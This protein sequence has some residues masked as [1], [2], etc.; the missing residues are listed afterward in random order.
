MP[1]GKPRDPRKEQH[2]R[3]LLERWQSSGL[4]VRA[5]CERHRD[6]PEVKVFLLGAGPGIGDQARER[7]NARVGREIVV[8][9]DQCI[10]VAAWYAQHPNAHAAP[11]RDPTALPGLTLW[12]ALCYRECPSDPAPA[13]RNT[14][15]CSESS[16]TTS[17]VRAT[18]A[19]I[20]AKSSALR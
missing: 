5:F 4:S 2:W 14:T 17:V 7:I 8:G 16:F 11:A 1:H 3:R 19:S 13:P 20:I 15:T 9:W 6:N 18:S 12:V 10:D